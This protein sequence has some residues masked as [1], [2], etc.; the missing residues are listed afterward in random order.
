MN[1]YRERSSRRTFL[2]RLGLTGA[3]GYLTLRTRPAAAEAPPETTRLK[4]GRGPS[5]CQAPQLLVDE[6][7]KLEGFTDVQHVARD[8]ASTSKFIARG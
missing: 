2:S 1:S 3:V 7:L 6:L 4:L 5:L 8:V